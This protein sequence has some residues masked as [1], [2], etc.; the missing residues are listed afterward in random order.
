MILRLA[1]KFLRKT[2]TVCCI[3]SISQLLP[4]SESGRLLHASITQCDI[5]SVPVDSS[6]PGRPYLVVVVCSQVYNAG[7]LTWQTESRV[8]NISIAEKNH[9][10]FGFVRIQA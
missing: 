6:F 9:L 3:I 7:H 8:H 5:S 10:R 4:E 1:V 2:E